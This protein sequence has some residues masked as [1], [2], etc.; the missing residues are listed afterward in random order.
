MPL[1]C[2]SRESLAPGPALGYC[3]PPESP[4][5]LKHADES[6]SRTRLLVGGPGRVGGYFFDLTGNYTVFYANAALAGMV[7]LIIVGSLYFTLSRRKLTVSP[8]G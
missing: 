8:A 2:Q 6:G 3:R 4:G 5:Q 1:R 7:N